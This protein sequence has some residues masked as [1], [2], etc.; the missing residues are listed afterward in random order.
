MRHNRQTYVHL[1]ET[2]DRFDG[3]Q[4]EHN[5]E[6]RPVLGK[7]FD[8]FCARGRL[9]VMSKERFVPEFLDRNRI[10]AS[11]MVRGVKDQCQF[12]LEHTERWQFA[13]RGLKGQHAEI[14]VPVYNF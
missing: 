8:Y 14:Q 7:R 10:P 3:S 2:L 5:I 1:D 12:V 11:Q 13:I 9:D 6:R 4:L